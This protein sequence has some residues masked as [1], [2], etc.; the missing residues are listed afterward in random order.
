M[1]K[2]K[3]EEQ[4]KRYTNENKNTNTKNQK[5]K[6]KEKMTKKTTDCLSTEIS[7]VLLGHPGALVHALALGSFRWLRDM[8]HG[9]R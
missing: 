5:Q 7:W 2:E 6:H 9:S 8:S 4:K 1:E 3:E